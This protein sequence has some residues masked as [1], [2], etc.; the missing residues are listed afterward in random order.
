MTVRLP[1]VAV[2]CLMPHPGREGRVYIYAYTRQPADITEAFVWH[3]RHAHDHNVWIAGGPGGNSGDICNNCAGWNGKE[4]RPLIEGQRHDMCQKGNGRFRGSNCGCQHRTVPNKTGM[5][6]RP[7]GTWHKVNPTKTPQPHE[8]TPVGDQ[9]HT[10][11]T[12][13]LFEEEPHDA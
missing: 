7:D 12:G 2:E 9:P 6:L 4:N 11:H 5:F 10:P 8:A 13:T 3:L 1:I